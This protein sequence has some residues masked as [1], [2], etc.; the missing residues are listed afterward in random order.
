MLRKIFLPFLFLLMMLNSIAQKDSVSYQMLEDDPYRIS[1]INLFASPLM[2][3]YDLS[4]Y[5]SLG[6]E[7]GASVRIGKKIEV[8]SSF[9]YT[10]LN[11]GTLLSDLGD[12]NYGFDHLEPIKQNMPFTWAEAGIAYVFSDKVR[13]QPHY[14]NLH[15]QQS[16]QLIIY[17]VLG[18]ES[19]LRRLR[20]VR[21]GF[22]RSTGMEW[23]Y[24]MLSTDSEEKYYTEDGV[25]FTSNSVVFPDVS[26][27]SLW[28]YE[29]SSYLNTNAY[30]D[31]TANLPIPATSNLFYIGYASEKIMNTLIDVENHGLRSKRASSEFY[32]DLIFGMVDY[33]PVLFYASD[34]AATVYGEEIKNEQ[35]EY[36]L[37][38]AASEMSPGRLGFRMGWMIKSPAF[39]NVVKWE[40]QV[41]NDQRLLYPYLRFSFGMLPTLR[42]SNSAFMD[43]TVGASFNL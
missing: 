28:S 7:G 27:G 38:A 17:N 33:G 1:K 35:K 19:D 11:L 15:T 6:V 34:P 32:M 36:E 37:D 22:I 13:K 9:Q 20:K 8:S 42:L 14:M 24:P 5:I 12:Y 40:E 31:Y 16:S 18:I 41:K 23:M 43:F 26:Y 10:Y 30:S 29:G 21:S 39:S 2:T 4:T 3:R 25:V